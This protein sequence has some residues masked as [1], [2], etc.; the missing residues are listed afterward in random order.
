MTAKP[1]LDLVVL[2]C[3]DA[4]D[5]ARFY[6]AVLGWDLE[7]SSDPDW[8][9]LTPPGGGLSPVER[10]GDGRLLVQVMGQR[11]SARAGSDAVSHVSIRPESLTIS[12]D[13]ALRARVMDCTYLGGRFR[14]KLDCAGETLVA[15]AP[16]RARV[17]DTLG[18]TLHDAWAF[19]DGGRAVNMVRAYDHA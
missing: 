6:G 14:L 18:V 13:A 9:T 17:G 1:S 11:V 10:T 15:F 8:A 5:L 7:E 16:R 2:D 19:R 4:L 3:P 12:D